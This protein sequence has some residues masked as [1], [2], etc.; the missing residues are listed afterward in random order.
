[1]EMSVY[2]DNQPFKVWAYSWGSSIS[3]TLRDAL[4]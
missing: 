1:M 2:I 3:I 4:L